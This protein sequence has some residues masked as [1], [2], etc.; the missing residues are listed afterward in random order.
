MRRDQF[1]YCLKI[2]Q[3][4]RTLETYFK[5]YHERNK[6]QTIKTNVI[7]SIIK[8]GGN[9]H[10]E[11]TGNKLKLII[12]RA[13]RIERLLN[14]ANNNYNIFDAFPDLN[15]TFFSANRMNTYNYERWLILV[16]TNNLVSADEGRRLYKEYK[17]KCKKE[18]YEYL[19][20]LYI[21]A[22][23][24]NDLLENEINDEQ[25]EKGEESEEDDKDEERINLLF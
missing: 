25:D 19:R 2:L 7:R 23:R 24:G 14:L 13:K 15:I 20:N 18:R 22:N 17:E 3:H 9:G 5:I 16:K 12:Q 11:L 21:G 10:L 6:G 4:F 1:R 8:S